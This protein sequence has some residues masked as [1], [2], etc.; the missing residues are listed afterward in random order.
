MSR[1]AL[2]RLQKEY[3]TIVREPVSNAVAVPDPKNWLRWH[4][5]IYGLE[6]PFEGGVYHGELL[7]PFNYPMGPPSIKMFTPNGRFIQN[8]KICTS[9]SDF[10]PESW[11]PIWNVGTIIT[12]LISFMQDNERSTGCETTTR[13][14]KVSLA[15]NSMKFNMSNPVFTSIFEDHLKFLEKFAYHEPEK[16]TEN[17]PYQENKKN[18]KQIIAVLIVLYLISLAFTR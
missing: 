18:W 11:T 15:K 17:I 4:Y 10:H 1:E 9:M 5:A 6:G 3:Q 13:G 16:T 2:S 8:Q 12:G 14:Q 7:F